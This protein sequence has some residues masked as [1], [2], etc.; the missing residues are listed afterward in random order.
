M[1]K[2]I[3]W[4]LYNK[5]TVK[6]IKGI[7]EILKVEGYEVKHSYL[8][9]YL[10]KRRRKA[11]N[12][13]KD[14]DKPLKKTNEEAGIDD[15]RS[16][17]IQQDGRQISEKLIYINEEQLKD[18]KFMLEAHGYSVEHW[19]LLSCRNNVWNTY[20]KK[21]GIQTLYSSKITVKPKLNS[22]SSEEVLKHFEEL[23]NKHDRPFLELQRPKEYGSMMLEIPIMDLHLSKLGW[24]Y[25]TGESYNH[26]IAEER[27]YGVITDILNR[28]ETNNIEKIIY[29][30]GQDY[31]NFD[32]PSGTTAGGT[33]QDS[34][35]RW[36]KM[37]LHGCELA[38]TI[39][40]R[41]SKVAPVD[42][43][44]VAGNHDK[45]ASY[46]L[47]LYLSAWFKND[48]NVKVDISPTRRKYVEYGNCLIGYSHGEMEKERISKAM[49]VEAKEAWGRTLYHEWHI[50]HLH[51]EKLTKEF[52]KT[53]DDEDGGLIVRHISSITGSDAW[54]TES[55]YVGAVKK[56][57]AFLWHKKFGLMNI[58]NSPIIIE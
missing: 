7:Q 13:L 29:P 52:Y 54:H 40:E 12:D 3:A 2:E 21:D 34:D 43:F 24:K 38:V 45:T 26:K 30:I 35:S 6:D 5:Q 18:V 27:L 48:D 49:Q 41:L 42:V 55:G 32:L 4:Q 28:V 39:I 17:E 16:I 22:I 36:Q 25:E 44:Y 19:D 11:E 31:Y 14:L 57:Q 23:L 53:V 10:G 33:P 51:K 37:F 1:W 9:S 46:Y 15:K 8:K 47:T 56:A 20:S 58:I 50:G